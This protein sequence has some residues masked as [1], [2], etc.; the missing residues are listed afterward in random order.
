MIACLCI[1][2]CKPAKEE[3]KGKLIITDTEYNVRQTHENSFVLD[4]TGKVKNIGE[5][6]VKKVV[7]TAFCRSCSEMMISESWFVSDCEKTEEQ[8]D[9]ISYLAIGGEEE[10]SLKDVALYFGPADLKP[11]KLPEKI[12]V[13]IES[14]DD[15][16]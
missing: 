4:A 12:E 14:Y 2:S 6:D 15:V 5:V 7:I 11:D 9:T 13:V 16:E 3:K 10:F 8:K 1:L